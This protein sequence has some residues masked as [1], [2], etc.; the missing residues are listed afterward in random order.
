MTST[1]VKLTCSQLRTQ[2]MPAS[3]RQEIPE[4]DA[5]PCRIETMLEVC[6]VEVRRSV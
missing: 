5:K 4:S 2:R 6:A 1:V 3:R